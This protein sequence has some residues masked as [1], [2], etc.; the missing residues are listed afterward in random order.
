MPL[1][2]L[3]SIP[4]AGL[5]IPPEVRSLCILKEKDIIDDSD[6]G[7]GEIYM[8]LKQ[9]VSG[10]VTTGI[11][12]AIV[13]MNRSEEDRRKDGVI[14]THTCWDV[15]VYDESP[16]D[17]VVRALIEKYHRPYHS[18]L[19]RLSTGIELGVDC[20]TMA[21]IGPPVGPDAG[22]KRPRV[23]LSNG[24]GTCPKGWI[25]SLAACFAD[26]FESKISINHPFKGGYIIRSHAKEI[27]WVQLELSREEFL[28]H[29]G[30]SERV[31]RAL[32]M[33]C[34]KMLF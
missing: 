9:D 16:S 28:S 34:A 10:L 19:S 8:P 27:P 29:E 23:C 25:E 1:P 6:G 7:A 17:H 12:R 11:A 13:D 24:D 15:L 18:D 21:E 14:K 5:E 22:I 4:H 33:W 26:A 30:K 3:L 2:L 20:H 31:L 32:T